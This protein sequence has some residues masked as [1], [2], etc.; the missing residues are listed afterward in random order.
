MCK[1]GDNTLCWYYHPEY[2]D[3]LDPP[4]AGAGNQIRFWFGVYLYEWIWE[5]GNVEL[6]YLG[7]FPDSHKQ[8]L[9]TNLLIKAWRKFFH[10]LTLLREISPRWVAVFTLLDNMNT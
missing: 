8:I 3:E 6:W 10:C 7:L 5:Y 4:D 9:I 1:E 2:I